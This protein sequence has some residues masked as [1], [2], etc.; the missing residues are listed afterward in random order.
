MYKEVPYFFLSYSRIDE[1]DA[2]RLKEDL[3]HA[4]FHI[5]MDRH[6][7]QWGGKWDDIVRE[8]IKKAVAILYLASPNSRSSPNV[9]HEID[10]AT[11][12]QRHILPLWIAGDTSWADIAAFG[13]SRINYIDL[14]ANK[15]KAGLVA[16]T[17]E[18]HST[19]DEYFL[20][21]D[22]TR[23]HSL[24]RLLSDE[25]VSIDES[26]SGTYK[27]YRMPEFA[28]NVLASASTKN[29][30]LFASS[31]FKRAQK[32]FSH[33]AQHIEPSIVPATPTISSLRNPYKGLYSFKYDDARELF[34]RERLVGEMVQ[35]VKHIVSEEKQHS[36]SSRCMLVVGAS[37][38]GKSSVVMA[39]LLPE[40]QKSQP[41]P[42]IK[43]W[44]FLEPVSPGERPIDSLVYALNLPFLNKQEAGS[45]LLATHRLD[46]VA[47]GSRGFSARGLLTLLQ[48]L[49]P[50][51]H[52]RV[53][54][55]IDQFEELFAPAIDQE[56]RELFINLLFTVATEPYSRA[57]IIVTLR[58]D[59]YDY[60][61]K[62]PRLFEIMKSH[63]IDIPPMH[64][65]ELRDVIERPVQNA[66]VNVTFDPDLTGDLVFEMRERPEALP[67]LQ[68]VLE[69]LFEQREGRRLT[70]RS[71]DALGG[72]QGAI[73]RHA[74]TTYNDLPL[75]LHREYTRQLFTQHFIHLTEARDE[76]SRLESGEGITR[77][78]VTRAE[79][80]LDDPESSIARETIEAFTAS[81]LL[82]AKSALRH[83]TRL[84]ESTYEISHEVLINAWERLRKWIEIDRE[85]IY[86]V[87]RLRPNITQWQNEETRKKKKQYLIEKRELKQFQNYSRRK[88]L[89]PQE[90]SFLHY[91]VLRRRIQTIGYVFLSALP[92]LL[93]I[94]FLLITKLFFPD[95]S[96]VTNLHDN[97]K[98]SLRQ[99]IAQANSGATIT[100]D[101]GLADKTIFLRGNDLLIHKNIVIRGPAKGHIVISSDTS[102]IIM[103]A[104]GSNVTFANITFANSY[105]HKNSFITNNGVL[106]LNDCLIANNKSYGDG[107]AIM[108]GGH[109]ILNDTLL[110]GNTDSGNGGAIYNLF[111]IMNINDSTITSNRAYNNG[112][113]IIVFGG[114]LE[115]LNSQVTLN[116]VADPATTVDYGG[117]IDIVDGSLYMSDTK[118]SKNIS[119]YYGGGIAIQGSVAFITDTTIDTNHA[120]AKGG[121]IIVAINTDNNF[122]SLVTL[123][124]ITV[125]DRPGARYY[126]GQN[127]SLNSREKDIAG[128]QKPVGPILQIA[129]NDE[130][131]G[132]AGNPP[133]GPATPGA[134]EFVRG[135]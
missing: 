58:A 5:W 65:Q 85:D 87:Q 17:E 69:K 113:G 91:N 63:R 30:T 12:Y 131:V 11:S 52:D 47:P 32:L 67:L 37:G 108:N 102:N 60:V 25:S 59:F 126:I 90:K 79:L 80:R 26:A 34:G 119:Q 96:I 44:L 66:D 122:S 92:I 16:L 53:V 20:P 28:D 36:Q 103:I 109:L 27:E 61:L 120:S 132:I 43:H 15:Y 2:L 97:G 6:N 71:Y 57:I 82:I 121:G 118:V 39:G 31:M 56:Q 50:D 62:Y 54:L 105:T 125:T 24:T 83:S 106:T 4:G 123:R 94:S 99:A 81:R 64:S 42:E 133:P 48:S 3:E 98:G 73:D 77:R 68:F 112:G 23:K 135:S 107:G 101:D 41:I 38:A 29:L 21:V 33:T 46:D 75:E 110:S 104:A 84:E 22:T 89:S 127:T 55:V 19:L 9:L 74:D 51:P 88:P 18:I 49:T 111:G 13:L 129:S 100:F 1:K 117:G 86:L 10:L 40:L 78:R 35:Q 130:K 14:R 72:L 114:D 45:S 95:P 115:M 128:I 116:T 76:L 124:N 70:R 7:I 93:T 8:A 134:E